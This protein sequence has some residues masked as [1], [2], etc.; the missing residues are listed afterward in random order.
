MKLDKFFYPKSIAVVGASKKEGKVGNTLFKK[1]KSFKDKKY[2]INADGYKIENIQTYKNLNK[3]KDKIDLLI[4]AVPASL[5][6]Q[7]V[8]D[9]A[10]KNIKNII[11]ISAGFSEIGRKYLEK[12]ILTIARKN[13]IRILGPNNFGFVNTKNNLDCTFSKLTPK[14]GL[15][16]FVS[17]SGALWSAIVDYSITNNIGFSKFISLGDMLDIDFNETIEY[18]SKDKETKAIFLYIESLKNGKEFMKVV[19][20]CKK[21]IVVVKAGKT[22]EG[23]VAVHSHT[24]SLAGSYEIYK[25]ACK[26]AGAI[27]AENLTEGLDLIKFLEMQNLPKRKNTL[28][29]TNAGGPGVLL[30]DALI[31][32]KINLAK[33]PQKI[34]FNLPLAANTKNPIDILGDAKSDRLIE[35]LNKIKKEQFY[36][37]LITIL[38]PQDMTNSYHFAQELIKFKKQTNKTMIACFMGSESFKESIKLLENNNIPVFFNLER[39]A[40]VLNNL[41]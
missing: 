13:Q 37:I 34:K 7:V 3:V 18:L 36:D 5:V 25:A 12:E 29:I 35:V 33:I 11:I 10:N 15:I 6:K 19:K 26:Q 20:Q 40:R 32:N 8:T 4:I 16:A 22:S 31:E 38:T 41:N 2:F 9:A 14:K 27:F 21:P 28:I 30:T 23:A 1:L 39:V 17:Q 24:G